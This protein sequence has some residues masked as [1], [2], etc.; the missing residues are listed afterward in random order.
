[1]I[2]RKHAL[3]FAD[4]L[5]TESPSFIGVVSKRGFGVRGTTSPGLACATPDHYL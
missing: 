3:S 2:Q 1:M 5:N 4:L